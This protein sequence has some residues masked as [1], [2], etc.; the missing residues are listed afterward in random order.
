MAGRI[1]EM[2]P[3]GFAG[4]SDGERVRGARVRHLLERSQG[5]SCHQLRRG[6]ERGAPLRGTST[7][8]FRRAGE[9]VRAVAAAE[10]RASGDRTGLE[11]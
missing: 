11:R 4:R 3:S 10:H 8:Q 6:S 1:L 7:A 5:S 2:E 9:G